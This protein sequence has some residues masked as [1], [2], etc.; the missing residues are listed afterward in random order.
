MSLV[1]RENGSLRPTRTA[2][3]WLKQGRDAQLCSLGDAW[4]N[5]DWN[6]LCHTPGLKCE[7]ENWHNDPILART[8]LFDAM[9]L[10]THWYHF[11]DLVEIIKLTNPDFQ[12]P[13]GNYDTWYIKDADHNGYL[14]VLTPGI[15]LKAV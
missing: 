1:R 5:S 2:I 7:G 13:D 4:S 12:R 6:D 8:A 14:P 9:P 10:T 11:S 15:M 3:G